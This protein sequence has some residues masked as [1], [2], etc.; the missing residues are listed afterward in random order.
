VTFRDLMGAKGVHLE[1]G[2]CISPLSPPMP[3]I[4]LQRTA[5][6]YS[7]LRRLEDL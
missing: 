1:W 5:G 6:D 3:L 4:F 7:A 2:G